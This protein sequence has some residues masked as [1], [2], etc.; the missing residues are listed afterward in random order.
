MTDYGDNIERYLRGDMTP[1]EMHAL[2]KKALDDP[3][4]ADAL[5]GA[6][7]L[8]PAELSSDIDALK[9]KISR[10]TISSP[11]I[12]RWYYQAAAAVLLTGITAVMVLYLSSREKTTTPIALN[13][14]QPEAAQQP[15]PASSDTVSSQP[16][17]TDDTREDDETRPVL[18][19]ASPSERPITSN[20]PA[21]GKADSKADEAIDES[22]I[23][24]AP[25]EEAAPLAE[26]DT[27]SDSE[28]A[29]QLATEPAVAHLET[30]Q[31]AARAF[32]ARGA[33]VNSRIVRGRV[34][35][36]EDGLP[37][38]GVNVMVDG[39]ATGTVTDLN[40]F[41]EINVPTQ[42]NTLVF[43]FVGLNTM[44]AS[45][46]ESTEDSATLDVKMAPDISALSE[47]VVVGYG[48]ENE[49]G[50]EEI[51][52]E[53]AEPEGGKR[54]FR[55]YLETNLRYPR[56]ALE[57]KIEGKVTV[58]FTIEPTG[59]LTD[60]KVVRGLGFGCDEE[61]IRLIREGP[62]WKPTKRNDEPVRGKGKV[63]LKFT[64]P[65]D[66]K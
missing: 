13:T 18:P 45:V 3:F 53:A 43:S 23:I 58:Q 42:A 2:E 55:R 52:W 6:S 9:E 34:T 12:G 36:A 44:Q 4:L 39:A 47:V 59:A 33:E 24:D 46:P 66:K 63:K 56:I 1:A 28:L 26:E 60:F 14:P 65:P 22:I 50:F 8:S 41:Y 61:V 40:G 21:A 7:G 57:N 31:G 38:P 48:N 20:A 32:R 27:P 19:Q 5:E 37:L 25:E 10:K 15:P 51:K 35:D 62:R 49:L 16:G 29:K 54:A 17:R 64:L 11:G 30:P